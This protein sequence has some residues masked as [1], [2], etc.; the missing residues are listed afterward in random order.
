MGR[1]LE[2]PYAVRRSLQ[3]DDEPANVDRGSSR[4]IVYHAVSTRAYQV[5]P[6]SLW[7]MPASLCSLSYRSPPVRGRAACCL[8]KVK[9]ARLTFARQRE[10]RGGTNQRLSAC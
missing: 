8:A 4:R 10:G 6:S 3:G 1:I 5:D 2:R 7:P 9:R